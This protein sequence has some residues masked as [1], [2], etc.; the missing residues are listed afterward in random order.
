[1][2]RCMLFLF[3]NLYMLYTPLLYMFVVNVDAFYEINES[4]IY[5]R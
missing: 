3:T 5:Y 1:M 2:Y 4:E